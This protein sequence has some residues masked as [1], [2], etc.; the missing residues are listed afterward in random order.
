MKERK[1]TISPISQKEYLYELPEERI[2]TQALKDR[3]ASKLLF[4]NKG[5]IRHEYFKGIS[6]LLPQNSL[7]VYNNTKVIPARIYFQKATGANIEIFL[8][9][10][11]A[12]TKVISL[13]MEQKEGCMWLTMIGNLRKWKDDDILVRELN[14]QEKTICLKA[15][16]ED[17]DRKLVSFEWDNPEISFVEIVQAAGEVPLPP[18]MNRKPNK[19]DIPRYQ[20]VYSEKEGAV[21]APTAGLHF[22]EE[23]IKDL[24]EK[25]IQTDYLTL[26]VSAGTFQ[27]IKEENVINHPMHAEQVVVSRENIHNLLQTNRKI[28]AVGTTSMRT[29]ESLYW[30]G[31]KLIKEGDP[32]FSIEKLIPYAYKEEELPTKEQSLQAILD[33]ME[34]EGKSEIMGETRIFIF[35]GY[36]FRICEGLI[37]NF[38]QPESTLILLVAA[39]VGER[40]RDI[41]NEALAQDYRF[42]S[43]GDSSLL[44]PSS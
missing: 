40:W 24:K 10:P 12:P 38:H 32:T 23:I 26:H 2:A 35:P 20:T 29:M 1:A 19:A 39:F 6:D 25:D 43:Y 8:L 11:E 5:K 42:L 37:T 18:Y 27:P 44:I 15:K 7:L 28:I 33:F 14:I 30:Y 34:K 41:Y 13:A 3:S 22:T 17:R 31:V 36:K 9:Q 16:I 4:Y 21:A